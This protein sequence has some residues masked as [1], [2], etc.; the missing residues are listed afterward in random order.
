MKTLQEIKNDPDFVDAPED[1]I[2][3]LCENKAF[4]N[5]EW[6]N[7][8]DSWDFPAGVFYCEKHLLGIYRK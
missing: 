8:G 7:Y 2:C 3:I 1:E 5:V 6:W 4:G